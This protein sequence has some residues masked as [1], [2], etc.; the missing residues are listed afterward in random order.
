[1]A[2]LVL[3][4]ELVPFLFVVYCLQLNDKYD[5]DE[6]RVRI[7]RSLGMGDSDALTMKCLNLV[8]SVSWSSLFSLLRCE[9]KTPTF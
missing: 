5:S 4:N 8:I 6:E 1:M 3:L 7:Y 9:P 2:R